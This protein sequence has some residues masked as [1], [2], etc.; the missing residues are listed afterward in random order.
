L[1]VNLRGQLRGKLSRP[2]WEMKNDYSLGA[3]YF[4]LREIESAIQCFFESRNRAATLGDLGQM[5]SCQFS[6]G[7]C[8]SQIGDFAKALD[9]YQSVSQF[10]QDETTRVNAGYVYLCLG[11]V[12]TANQLYTNALSVAERMQDESLRGLSL[13]NLAVLYNQIGQFQQGLEAAQQSLRLARTPRS[14]S[15]RCRYLAVAHHHLGDLSEAGRCYEEALALDVAETNYACAVQIG[16][17]CLEDT[18]PA[19]A[20]KH[21]AQGMGLCQN[22]LRQTPRLY[23]AIY[24]LALAQLADGQPE[25]AI[26]TYKRAIAA[27]AANGIVQVALQDLRLLE[28]AMP[29]T[30]GLDDVRRILETAADTSAAHP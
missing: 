23:N 9:C 10:T 11:D 27:C 15:Y 4:G 7:T 21:L 16:I 20:R 3:A 18:K 26:P 12:E 6:L 19:E 14:R 29:S 24:F 28:R 17:L 5:L 1:I 22:L 2:D 30:V 25:E 8:Y 13:S